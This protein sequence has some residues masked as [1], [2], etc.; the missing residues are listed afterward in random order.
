LGTLGLTLFI[1]L[2]SGIYPALY[3][4][5]IPTL[6]ALKGAFKN[7]KSSMYL[8]KSLTTLQFAISIF[9]VVCTL[10]MQDQ[11]DYVRTKDLGF[12]K[13]NVVLLQIQDTAV[14]NHINAI[15]T[16][17]EQN[18][19]VIGSTVSYSVPGLNVGGGPVMLA[20]T[21]QGMTQQAF[22]AMWVGD[23]YLKTMN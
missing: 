20:E 10:F 4:P 16:E 2:L 15:R 13:E 14:Q 5:S 8:R 7:R 23:D 1:G 11:I 3:L 22:T 19:K 17:F 12:D 18:P 21:D 6:N 9:V